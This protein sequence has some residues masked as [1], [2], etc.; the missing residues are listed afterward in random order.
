VEWRIFKEQI[1][2]LPARLIQETK[3]ALRKWLDVAAEIGVLHEVNH[4]IE[5]R[6]REACRA[7]MNESVVMLSEAEA[8]LQPTKKA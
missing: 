5:I 4:V 6:I 1:D 8:G 2:T 7:L 3:E